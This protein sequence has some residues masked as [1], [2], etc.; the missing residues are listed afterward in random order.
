MFTFKLSPI[1]EILFSCSFSIQSL[2]QWNGTEP[3]LTAHPSHCLLYQVYH[4]PRL[5]LRASAYSCSSDSDG[6]ALREEASPESVWAMWSV[7]LF[8]CLF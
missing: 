8:V 6:V 1:Y 2:K 7:C 5:S 3:L 4:H